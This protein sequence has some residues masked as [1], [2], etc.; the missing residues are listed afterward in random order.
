MKTLGM[1]SK[2]I[3][4]VFDFSAKKMIYLEEEF[5]FLNLYINLEKLRF[6][7]SLTVNINISDYIKDNLY[8][9]KAPPLLIQPI[10]ENAFEHG[11]LHKIGDKILD[12]YF[13]MEGKYLKCI[14]QDNGV[15]RSFTSTSNQWEIK[16][17]RLSGLKLTQE[18]LLMLDDSSNQTNNIPL[19]LIIDLK[20]DSDKK[21]I[22][23]RIEMLI[24]V[25]I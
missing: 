15:G 14:V 21:P 7:D 9:L 20:S 19:F 8:A 18:R 4:D 1:F 5:T 11:L 10:I 24:K 6:D 3:R 13:E 2:L 23:T 22:G 25:I 16:Q 12:I 17:D